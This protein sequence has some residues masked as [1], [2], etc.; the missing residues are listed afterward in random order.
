MTG[1]GS[2]VIDGISVTPVGRNHWNLSSL[3]AAGTTRA[4][5][6]SMVGAARPP[7]SAL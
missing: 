7:V 6:L 4:G 1:T 5:V 2:V 3:V